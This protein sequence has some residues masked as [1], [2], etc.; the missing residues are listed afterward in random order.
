MMSQTLKIPLKMRL[1]M[2]L[3]I[4][5]GMRYSSALF[6]FAS[7]GIYL[8]LFALALALNRYHPYKEWPHGK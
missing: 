4:R 8:A 3:D 2:R 5:L 6:S 7:F 1:S